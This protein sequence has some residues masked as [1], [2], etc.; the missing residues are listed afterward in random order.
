MEP[1]R[2]GTSPN[3]ARYEA[4]DSSCLA[5]CIQRLLGSGPTLGTW[6]GMQVT[7]GHLR[8]PG[9][10]RPAQKGAQKTIYIGFQGGV[11]PWGVSK[12]GK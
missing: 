10:V 3:A 12:G 7:G 5:W 8:P 4:H 2:A 11:L 9:P 6:Q 1:H